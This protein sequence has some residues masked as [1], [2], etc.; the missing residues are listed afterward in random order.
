VVSHATGDFEPERA[1]AAARGWQSAKSQVVLRS[2][3]EIRALF[4]GL[5]ILE[6]GVVLVPQWRPEEGAVPESDKV[7]LYGCVGVKG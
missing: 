5:E 7:W 4:W 3:A 6:P 1:G 2:E